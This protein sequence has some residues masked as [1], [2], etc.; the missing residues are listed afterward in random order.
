VAAAAQNISVR[1]SSDGHPALEVRV[2]DRGGEVRVAVH[3]PDS[4]TSESVR[5]GLPELVDRLSQRGYETEIWRGPSVPQHSSSSAQRDSAS[6]SGRG[7]HEQ[8]GRDQ[9]RHHQQ[10]QQENQPT[11]LKEF[12]ASFKPETT[13]A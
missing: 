12:E 3:S 9:Q 4:A 1:L 8:P 7:G 10:Q 6:S 5:A 11:W 2:M 13:G